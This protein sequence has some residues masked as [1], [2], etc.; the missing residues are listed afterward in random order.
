MNN[1][2]IIRNGFKIG[3]VTITGI[4]NQPTLILDEQSLVTQNILKQNLDNK[5]G[6]SGSTLNYIDFNT[7][8]TVSPQTGRVFYDR[9]RTF[10]SST[11]INVKP[12][13]FGWK[14]FLLTSIYILLMIFI[15]LLFYKIR[16]EKRRYLRKLRGA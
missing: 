10:E 11:V 14:E 3:D 5:L 4:T 1:I 15:V 12:K 9:K 6:I 13:E 16:K 7:G 8:Q 2:H